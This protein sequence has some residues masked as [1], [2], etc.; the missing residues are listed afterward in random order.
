MGIL[1]KVLYK[2]AGTNEEIQQIYVEKGPCNEYIDA[3]M[4]FQKKPSGFDKCLNAD[5]LI[6]LERYDEAEELLNSVKINAFS[7]DDI[8]S[9][10]NYVKANLYLRTGRREEAGE[11]FHKNEKLF[12]IYFQSPSKMRYFGAYLDLAADIVSGEGD[13]KGAMYHIGRMRN[14]SQKYEPNFPVMSR[15]SYVRVLKNLGIEKEIF[16][17]EYDSTKSFIENYDGYKMQW[18]KENMLDQL[19]KAAK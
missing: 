16:Q 4:A 3:L 17:A 11:I 8:K 15:I 18:Q 5:M 1:K 10:G 13:E 2:L 19:E 7:D 12:E 9:M 14:W 6:S